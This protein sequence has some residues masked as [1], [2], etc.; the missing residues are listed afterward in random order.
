MRL[1]PRSSSA[2]LEKKRLFNTD[3]RRRQRTYFLV[4]DKCYDD[5]GISEEIAK[6]GARKLCRN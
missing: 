4:Y 1:T 6:V 2:L 3:T 5:D